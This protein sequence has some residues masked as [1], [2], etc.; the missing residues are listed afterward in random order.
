MT[1]LG[2]LLIIQRL[3]IDMQVN[4]KLINI[5]SFIFFQELFED[6]CHWI[7][8]SMCIFCVCV[9]ISKW[10]IHWMSLWHYTNSAEWSSSWQ[11]TPPV[12]YI[13]SLPIVSEMSASLQFEFMWYYTSKCSH[14]K[15]FHCSR[16]KWK[17]GTTCPSCSRVKWKKGTTYPPFDSLSFLNKIVNI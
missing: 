8:K 15:L 7:L 17:K 9:C 16:V 13:S 6:K 12:E 2:F 10:A 1:K 14:I 4:T 3:I 11:Y 5:S